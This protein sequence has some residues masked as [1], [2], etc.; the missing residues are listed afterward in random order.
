MNV[1]KTPHIA[2]RLV[3][4]AMG[5]GPRG[6]LDLAH[7]KAL[8]HHIFQ[9]V[10]E[11]AGHTRDERVRLADGELA[12][13]PT[14]RK[15]EGEDFAIGPHIPDRLNRVFAELAAEDH[16][17]G[18]DRETFA[19]KAGELLAEINSVHPFREGNGR[20]QRAFMVALGERAGHTL[21]LDVVSRERMFRTSVAAHEHGGVSGFQ[22][23]IRKITDPQR[24]S[25]LRE[26]QSFLD[27]HQ[28]AVDWRDHYMA[29]SEGERTYTLTLVG[30][31]G[32]NFM[33]RTSTEILVGRSSDL[34]NPPPQNGETVTITTAARQSEEQSHAQR[35]SRGINVTPVA[36]ADGSQKSGP[37]KI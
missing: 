24:V 21:R 3:E 34:P 5:A 26:A 6:N 8:H 12:Y 7:L 10:Y 31:A 36:G 27:Q 30:R 20:T 25:A 29:T 15:V 32:P 18:L 2:I 17:R 35:L 16:W 11:W 23:M 1:W 4:I 13:Q 19:M 9:D 37:Q 14:L 22:R 28:G 33:A